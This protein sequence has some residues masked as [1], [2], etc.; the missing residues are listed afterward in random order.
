MPDLLGHLPRP[1]G[2]VL[3]FRRDVLDTGRGADRERKFCW[4]GGDDDLPLIGALGTRQLPRSPQTQSDQPSGINGECPRS[5]RYPTAIDYWRRMKKRGPWAVAINSYLLL[6]SVDTSSWNRL[7]GLM[8]GAAIKSRWRPLQVTVKGQHRS[9][10]GIGIPSLS[11]FLPAPF[12]PLV[13]ICSYLDNNG[14]FIARVCSTSFSARRAVGHSFHS[15]TAS[16]IAL[17]SIYSLLD[18]DEWTTTVCPFP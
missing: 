10:D 4:R 5:D 13:L 6:W 9:D 15:L 17:V 12:I 8:G 14:T 18:C 7:P 2:T 1:V 11:H 3:P 16:D